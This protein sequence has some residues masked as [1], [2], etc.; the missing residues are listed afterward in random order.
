[1]ESIEELFRK[2]IEDQVF[3]RE[4][5]RTI[6]KALQEEELDPKTLGHLKA[7]LFQM[8]GEEMDDMRNDRILEWLRQAV[9]LLVKAGKPIYDH[10]VYFSP[11]SDCLRAIREQIQQTRSQL[12]ICVFTISDD[13]ISKEIIAAH[14]RRVNVRIITD[15]DK[16][17]DRGSDVERFA[18][19]GIDV[20]V[21]QTRYHMHH[22]FALIDQKILLTGSYNWTRSAAENNEEN[23]LLTDQPD[24]VKPYQKAFQDMWRQ[25][26]PFQ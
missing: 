14:K 22:K 12:D 10:Q 9:K 17:Y 19:E 13:R 2:A 11:G 20:R 6:A 21:D 18:K 23:I 4:E 25:M 8:A 1:M 24:L 5:R 16:L 7:Q 3:T 15:N 26:T